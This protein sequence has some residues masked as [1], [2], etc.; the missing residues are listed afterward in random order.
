MRTAGIVGITV[1]ITLVVVFGGLFALVSSMDT[2][3]GVRQTTEFGK[4]DELQEQTSQPVKSTTSMDYSGNAKYFTGKVTGIIDGDT[5]LVDGQSIRFALAS[6]PELNKPMGLAAKKYVQEICP[7][8]SKVT[9][10]EDDGQ[11]Q[12]SYGRIVAL[13]TC[14]GVNL[15]EA[16]IEKGFGHLS[17]VHCDK[18]EFSDNAW[19]GCGTTQQ[20]T[21]P[22]TTSNCDPNYSGA[23][24]PINS[25]DLDCADVGKNI[26]VTGSD[27]HGLDR[28]GDGIGCEG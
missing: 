7:I 11:T 12:G 2:S 19:S 17:F 22:Q 15:N 6:T 25:P 28:D 16:I 27:P 10:D 21:S 18:S 4:T 23:C 26:K 3:Q 14:N 20:G 1:V 24:I 8:G 5:I 9:V 13:V